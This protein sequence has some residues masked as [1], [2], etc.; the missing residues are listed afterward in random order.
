MYREYAG[1]KQFFLAPTADHATSYFFHQQE[2]EAAVRS[3][4]ARFLPEMQG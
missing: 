1:P 4:L 2:Y 3:F